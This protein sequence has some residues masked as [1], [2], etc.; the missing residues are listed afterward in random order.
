MRGWKGLDPAAHRPASPPGRGSQGALGSLRLGETK[1]AVRFLWLLG[2]E[3][4]DRPASWVVRRGEGISESWHRAGD[5]HALAH[6]LQK[7]WWGWVGSQGPRQDGS[8]R[9]TLPRSVRAAWRSLLETLGG[10]EEG[11][12]SAQIRMR[13]AVGGFAAR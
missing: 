13:M 7:S 12:L 3:T 4:Q 8:Q 6:I 11:P 5:N 1:T 9:T 2:M 10:T